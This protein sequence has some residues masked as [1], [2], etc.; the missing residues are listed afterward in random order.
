MAQTPAAADTSL[1]QSRQREVAGSRQWSPQF[2]SSDTSAA[3]T[4][5]VMTPQDR[6]ELREQIQ[7]TEASRLPQPVPRSTPGSN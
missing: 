7:S 6:L 5:R 1:K 2:S 4:P 3:V